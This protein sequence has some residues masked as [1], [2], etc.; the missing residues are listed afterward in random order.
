MVCGKV[1]PI[2]LQLRSISQF[3]MLFFGNLLCKLKEHLMEIYDN[4]LVVKEGSMAPFQ[5]GA[6]LP[7][8]EAKWGHVALPGG[9]YGPILPQIAKMGPY[10]PP[11]RAIWPQPPALEKKEGGELFCLQGGQYGP[12]CP[13][14]PHG[15]KK[16][17]GV[18]SAGILDLLSVDL[19]FFWIESSGLV[20]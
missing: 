1:G 5:N 9:Q 2:F 6:M 19:D 16:K 15:A 7:S 11:W 10:C 8:L 18:N 17:R 12:I 3:P 4:L 13:I 20:S 14:L